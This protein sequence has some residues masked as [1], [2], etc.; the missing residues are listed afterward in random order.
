M[1]DIIGFQGDIDE[2]SCKMEHVINDEFESRLEELLGFPELRLDGEKIPL[3]NLI[4]DLT[5]YS[6]KYSAL[7][8]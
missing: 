6:I 7:L 4:F 2:M 1:K 3:I 5:K 8:F